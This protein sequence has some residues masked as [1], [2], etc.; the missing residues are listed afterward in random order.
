MSES[1]NHLAFGATPSGLV[2]KPL[3]IFVYAVCLSIVLKGGITAE[4]KTQFRI[5]SEFVVYTWSLGFVNLVFCQGSLNGLGIRP[6]TP[7]GLLGIFFS[8]FLHAD[9][10]HLVANTIPFFILGWFVMLGGI[11]DFFIVTAFTAL[12]SGLGIWMF[13]RPYTTHVGASDVIF[14]YLGFLLLH[15]Y[16]ESNALFI[17]LSALVGFLYGRLLWGVFPVQAGVSWEGHLFGL[18]GGVLAARFLI[19][20]KAMF[21]G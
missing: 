14:G 6:R 4:L 9:W 11:T 12:F 16:F 19:V 10:E 21:P 1:L 18:I 7:M 3:E 20:F 2:M 13:G 17:V 8:P 5:L 15:S